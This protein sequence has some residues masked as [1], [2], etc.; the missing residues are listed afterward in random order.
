MET[1]VLLYSIL[2][3]FSVLVM[4]AVILIIAGRDMFYAFYRRIVPKGNDVFVANPNRQISH[5]YKKSKD[6]LFKIYVSMYLT[7][8]E[9][10]RRWRMGSKKGLARLSAEYSQ[11]GG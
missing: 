4:G 3:I 1:I 6:G 9:V 5:Y 8:P 7:N 2:G 10:V 11:T